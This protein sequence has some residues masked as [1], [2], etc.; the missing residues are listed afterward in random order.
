L[1]LGSVR[2]YSGNQFGPGPLV[3]ALAA[4]SGGFAFVTFRERV[5]IEGDRGLAPYSSS[6]P[7]LARFDL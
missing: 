5:V 7:F 4:R 1:L 2:R 3:L 6:S